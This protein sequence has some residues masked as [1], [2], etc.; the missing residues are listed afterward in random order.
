LTLSNT[1]TDIDQV[2]VVLTLT[3]NI[4]TAQQRLAISINGKKLGVVVVK[5]G[6]TTL[7]ATYPIN[8]TNPPGNGGDA[9]ALHYGTA[10]Y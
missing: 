4:L 10:H 3:D 6:S 9:A 1:L 5:P 2:Q 7:T 8:W